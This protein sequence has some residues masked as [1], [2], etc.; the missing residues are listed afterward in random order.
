MQ[1]Q[2]DLT[3]PGAGTTA[4]QPYSVLMSVY[5]NDDPAFLAQAVESMLRQTVKPEQFV[6]VLDGPVGEPLAAVVDGYEK[7]SPSLF[8]VVRLA[9]NGGLGHALNEGLGYCRNEL[10]ARMD[11][12]DISF[13]ERCEKQLRRFAEKPDMVILGTQIKE[14]VGTTDHVVSMRTVPCSYEEIL[15]FSRRRSPFNHPTVMYK[16]SEIQALGGYPCLNR[17]EDLQLFIAA[18][19]EGRYAENLAEP[20]LYYRTSSDNQKRRKTWVNCKEY[21][22]VMHGFYKKKQIGTIDMLYVILGQTA[23]FL[24]PD[25]FSALLSKRFLRKD[26][27]NDA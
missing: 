23:L 7:A 24:L 25:G 21:I 13:P 18:V 22:Q 15:L 16:K 9:K 14:F 10:V 19:Q 20:L 6:L 26:A 2:N 8:T 27:Q 5:K 3:A 12:D 1:N 17:K 11:A 4:A